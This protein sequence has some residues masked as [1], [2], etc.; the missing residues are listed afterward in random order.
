MTIPTAMTPPRKNV[1]FLF[2]DIAIRNG[3]HLF[4]VWFCREKVQ[5]SNFLGKKLEFN[6]V[7]INV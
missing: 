7:A 6:S 4:A 3:G 5:G 2:V 1:W